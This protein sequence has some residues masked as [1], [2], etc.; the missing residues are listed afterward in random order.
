MTKRAIGILLLLAFS[1]TAVGVVTEKEVKYNYEIL[2][3][4][5]LKLE[6]IPNS[7][8]RLD[9]I[10]VKS[11]DKNLLL[12]RVLS[13]VS[14]DPLYEFY[15]NNTFGCGENFWKN[16]V[17][18]R[19]G[20]S[21][22]LRQGTHCITFKSK[23]YG[24]L[25]IDVTRTVFLDSNGTF[26]TFEAEFFNKDSKKD[27]YLAPWYSFFPK[28]SNSTFLIIPAA[29]GKNI[30]SLGNVKIFSKDHLAKNPL[31]LVAAIKNW[32]ATVYPESQ[33]ILA[34]II[35]KEEVLPN[36]AFYSWHGQYKKIPYRSMEGIFAG[37]TLKSKAKRKVK[38]TFAVFLGL[39]DIKDVA[40][41]TAI[42]AVIIDKKLS[43]TLAAAKN[44]HAGK[45]TVNVVY[46][47]FSKSY[48][49]NIPEITPGKPYNFVLNLDGD[50]VKN[51]TG[52][53]SDKS[54]FDLLGF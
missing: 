11:A 9:Q 52:L 44:L 21:Q 46:E 30:H 8:G 38:C 25:P 24:A 34:M 40:G 4:Q 26:F 23:W 10:Y 41:T 14:V 45:T 20:K 28:D 36:G 27:F 31:G 51:V 15:R 42:D 37:S 5:F 43:I 1:V 53:L 39:K 49:V 16:Y 48:V 12:R 35:P 7:F 50:K 32:T 22:V 18:K 13:K 29:G 47:K 17:A 19:D 6:F 33:I 2:E 3:N 54:T